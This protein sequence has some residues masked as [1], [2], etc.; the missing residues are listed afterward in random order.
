MGKFFIIIGRKS[1]DERKKEAGTLWI[2][3]QII[4]LNIGGKCEREDATSDQRN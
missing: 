2:C 3:F 4:T 1:R